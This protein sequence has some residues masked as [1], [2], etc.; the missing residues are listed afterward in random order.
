MFETLIRNGKIINGAGNPWFKADI[1]IKNGMIAKIGLLHDAEAKREIDAEGLVVSPGFIDIHTHSD[2]PHLLYPQAENYIRQGVTTMVF[3]NCGT[4]IAPLN[5]EMKDEIIKDNPELK[6]AGLDWETYDEYLI[7]QEKIGTSVNIAPLIGFGTV[8]R[9]VMGW[10]MRAPSKKELD[11]MKSEVEKAMKAGAFGITTGLR[12]DPQSYA[13]TDEVIELAKIVA[14][15]GGFYTT[16]QRDEGDRDDPIGSVREVIEIGEK[17]GLPVNISHFEIL[18]KHHWDKLEEEICMIENARARGVDITADQ[19]PYTGSGTSPRAWIPKWANEGGIDALAK[20]LKDPDTSR[21]IKE[22]LIQVMDWRGGPETVLIRSYPLNDAYV[23]K[24]V[25]EVAK[26]LGKDPGDTYFDLFKEHVE[27]VV[28]GKI[29]GNFG[30]VAFCLQDK[31]VITIM[32]KPWV[33]H[34]SDG[35]AH[36]LGIE[37]GV[38]PR[39]YGTFPR[40]LG[41]YVREKKI[42]SLE[43]AVRKMTSLVTQRLGIFDRGIIAK[44]IWADLT[45]FDPDKVIDK[46]QWAPQKEVMQYPEG[47]PYVIVNG[48]ITLDK[49][50]HTGALAGKVLRKKQ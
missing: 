44:G 48:V 31:D 27:K 6:K 49:G 36:K 35:R 20:R 34:S 1:A 11:D 41:K 28:S 29:S 23:G 39:W 40:V 26:K 38:H 33:M 32:Q 13:K 7:K 3:P 8:R 2:I 14:K 45:I 30:V 47:I 10:E 42:I 21:M 50:K 22:G 18:V 16:H 19:Y 46:A 25:A 15:Y 5:E 12:Y 9:Y 43:E 17:A 24:T 4:G 37:S